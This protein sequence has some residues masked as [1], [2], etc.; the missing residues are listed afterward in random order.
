M[1]ILFVVEH[2]YPHIGGAEKLLLDLATSLIE[3]GQN[4]V[5]LTSNSGGIKGK[6]S[7]SG[8]EIHSFEWKSFFGHPVPNKT[9]IQKHIEWADVVQT[10]QYTAAPTALK[11][12]KK[13]GKPCVLMSYEYLGKKWKAVDSS[14]KAKLFQIFEWWVFHKPYAHYIAI[15]NASKLDMVKGGIKSSQIKVVYPVFNDFSF[16]SPEKAIKSTTPTK[17]FLYYGRPGKTK[18]VF[19][20]LEAIR[21]LNSA[22]GASI[23][24]SFILSN[25]PASE[26]EK[27]VSLVNKYNLGQRINILESQSQEKLKNL[28]LSSYCVVVPSI[29]EGFGYSAYQ[30]CLLGKNIITSDAGSLPEVIFGRAIVFKSGDGFSLVK[31]ILMAENNEFKKYTRRIKGN[32]TQQVINLYRDLLS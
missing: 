10:A 22:L 2:F 15:S 19:L 32:Q 17:I 13:A 28:I 1:N 9:D 12:A 18:G 21:M 11:C 8:I 31:A 16:W 4:V 14:A 24:F 3:Q 7:Y 30:A 25:D 6:H 27:F 29:T 20:L 26:R 23:V 5:V